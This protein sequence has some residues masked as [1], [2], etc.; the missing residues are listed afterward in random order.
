MVIGAAIKIATT[1]YKHRKA[2]YTVLT[3]QDKYIGAAWKGGRYGKATQYGVRTGAAAGALIGSLISNEAED[4]PGN[5]IQT[6]I[7]NGKRFTPR[8][9][10]QTRGRYT[11]R[12]GRRCISN[13]KYRYRSR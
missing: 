8:K 1:V 3:A 13:R 9:P 7:R 6:P 5:G 12:A 2:I 11:E 4:T 10:Y